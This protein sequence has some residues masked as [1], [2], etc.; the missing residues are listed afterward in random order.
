MWLYPNH[1]DPTAVE[2]A[3]SPKNRD[4]YPEVHDLPGVRADSRKNPPAAG[5][6]LGGDIV[7][8]DIEQTA[9]R[10]LAAAAPAASSLQDHARGGRL[11]GAISRQQADTLGEAVFRESALREAAMRES[12]EAAEDD[13]DAADP[14]SDCDCDAD[15]DHEC[16]SGGN[17]EPSPTAAAGPVAGPFPPLKAKGTN[18]RGV[19]PQPGLLSHLQVGGRM[20]GESALADLLG[21][22]MALSGFH[23]ERDVE[24]YLDALQRGE[25][26]YQ[27]TALFNKIAGEGGAT[28]LVTESYVQ[29]FTKKVEGAK[30]A[31]RFSQRG[32]GALKALFQQTGIPLL[33]SDVLAIPTEAT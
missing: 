17:C 2:F 12:A 14:G 32:G 9:E 33:C 5:V 26:S 21:P 25:T 30:T 19:V 10:L 16:T 6:V 23:S 7:F 8:E 31:A 4:C 1:V 3:T 18:A 13:I 11:Q 22:P 15:D 24:I 27:V 20:R 28:H 29:K